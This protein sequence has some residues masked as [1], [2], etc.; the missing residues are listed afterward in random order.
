MADIPQTVYDLID[1]A[2]SRNDR[3]L[4]A[5]DG[6]CGSGKTTLAAQLGVHYGYSVIHMDDFF[7][8]PEQ[9]TPE[10]LATPGENIDHERFLEEVLTPLRQ[11]GRCVY[12]PF[13][14]GT[15]TLGDATEVVFSQ[16][17]VIEGSYACHP[18]LYEAYDVR[19]FVTTDPDE[20]LRRITQRNGEKAAT[21]FR[22]KWIPLEE[23]YFAAFD[24]AA[25]CD[26][27]IHT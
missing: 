9:R 13:R 23:A 4:I 24:V 5:I 3:V 1:R 8:R 11:T 10:R 16:L 7:L 20:Q 25:G 14:C 15:Q 22:D 27:Q 12:R 18:S 6:R 19:L 17:C 26:I 2:L 21:V